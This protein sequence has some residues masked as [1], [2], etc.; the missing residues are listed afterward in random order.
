MGRSARCSLWKEIKQNI[1]G[2]NVNLPK[3]AFYFFPNIKKLIGKKI[4]NTTIKSANDLCMYYLK[5]SRVS[6]VPGEDFGAPD[7]IRLSY[8]ASEKDLVEAVNRMI[9][10][11]NKL[12]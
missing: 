9:V 7:C 3:G 12:Y 1:K 6:L 2:F 8:A 10:S 5:D 4:E 11:T